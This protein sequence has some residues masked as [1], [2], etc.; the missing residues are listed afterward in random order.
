[1][2]LKT[3]ATNKSNSSCDALLKKNG[4]EKPQ[5]LVKSGREYPIFSRERK[6]NIGQKWLSRF[7][8]FTGKENWLSH[9]LS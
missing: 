2:K 9:K 6:P 1:M 7:F 5:N 3:K 4:R 8:F